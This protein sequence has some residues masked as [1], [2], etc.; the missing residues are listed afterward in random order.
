MSLLGDAAAMSVD[1]FTYF[2]NMYAEYIK[3][4][5][6][7][8]SKRM[9]II[10]EIGIPSFSVCALLGVT[11]YITSDAI[12]LLMTNGE[13]DDDVNI[14]F[15]YGFAGANLIVDIISSYMFYRR[16][17]SVFLSTLSRDSTEDIM[18]N[19]VQLTSEKNEE[20]YH[21]SVM[22]PISTEQIH[23]S[24]RSSTSTTPK[25]RA[26]LNMISAF[27]HV[28]GDSMRT[29]SVFIAAIISSATLA[30]G[31]VCDAWAS[32]VVTITILICIIPLILEIIKAV[33]HHM[34]DYESMRSIDSN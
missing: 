16:R 12:H 14:F 8:L 7:K 28:G 30:R 9:L 10:L 19:H 27:T 26:N 23:T 6:E 25:T 4:K 34:T 1:V 11:G 32:I 18:L 13:E 5:G 17:H 21:D 22:N 31:N 2:T 24:S 20:N 15:L 33:K 3:S 29:I